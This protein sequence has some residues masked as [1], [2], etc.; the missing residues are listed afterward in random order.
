MSK[1]RQSNENTQ[2]TQNNENNKNIKNI[3]N[4]K[5]T[6]KQLAD[7]EAEDNTEEIEKMEIVS[8]NKFPK[9]DLSEWVQGYRT[10]GFQ[11]TNLHR[12]IT[13][14]L[15]AKRNKSKMFLGFTSNLVSSGLR[16]ILCTLAKHSC[17][18]V[19]V[20]TAG[21]IEEDII[22]THHPSRLGEFDLDGATLRSN[23]LNRVGN[24]L[25][26]NQNYFSFEVWLT[27]FLDTLLS[28]DVLPLEQP[29]D[30]D[31]P[32]EQGY[33]QINDLTIITPS[34]FIYELGKKAQA[35][36]SFLYWAYKNKIPVYCPGLTDGSIGD[37][38]TYYNKRK[39][40]II[41]TVEDIAKINGEG[42]FETS[43]AALV[44]GAGI[45]KHHILNAN[46]FRNGLDHCVLVNTAQE[47]DG[48]DAGARIDESVSWGKVKKH[49][50]SVKVHADATI[51]L[52]ILVHSVWPE[53]F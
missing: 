37:I 9:T 21:G 40:L 20:T 51:I 48:S 53:Y 17:I 16:D 14:L 2:N 15:V 43:T 11:G 34:R 41:D 19:I 12:A 23:G 30:Q 25:I 35:E 38:I 39:Q 10:V 4:N 6:I 46:L 47:Y 18:D 52:P 29:E 8:G 33:R 22:K 44:L 42:L 3:K 13:E 24:V 32:I 26:P 28:G 1:L 50:N 5:N 27:E 36:D 45:I 31:A 49:T 7:S